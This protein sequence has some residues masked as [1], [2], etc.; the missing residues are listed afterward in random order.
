MILQTALKTNTLYVAQRAVYDE[1][2]A[3]W[4]AK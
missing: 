1:T 4:D 2:R 3:F